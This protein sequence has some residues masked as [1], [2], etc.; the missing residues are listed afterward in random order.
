MEAVGHCICY[1]DIP[2][3]IGNGWMTDE[4]DNLIV[5]WT[6]GDMMPQQL[7]DILA[8]NEPKIS[9]IYVDINV[10]EA[11]EELVEEDDEVDNILDIVF[12]DDQDY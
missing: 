7:I 12:E 11:Q 5:Q 4:G 3:P 10:D 6:D 1:V 8:D 2:S 9:T